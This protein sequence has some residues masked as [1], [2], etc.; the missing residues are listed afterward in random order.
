MAADDDFFG[1]CEETIAHLLDPGKESCQSD[2]ES[3]RA[4]VRAFSPS[5]GL[6]NEG[7]QEIQRFQLYLVSCGYSFH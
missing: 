6:G 2:K 5:L 4:A 3:R 7:G 1:Y